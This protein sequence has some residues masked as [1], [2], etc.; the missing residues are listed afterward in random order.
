MPVSINVNPADLT[1]A[2]CLLI[3]AVNERL[4]GRYGST[5]GYADIACEL[6]TSANAIR[7]RQ[8]RLGDLPPRIPFLKAARWPTPLIAHWLCSLANSPIDASIAVTK[9]AHGT[10]PH[11]AK[12][13]RG[14]PRVRRAVSVI[15]R[16]SGAKAAQP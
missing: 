11:H 6:Q 3:T 16:A 10:E 5:M 15:N 12:P 13:A 8:F 14:R 9:S 4:L 2:I 7:L 1:S